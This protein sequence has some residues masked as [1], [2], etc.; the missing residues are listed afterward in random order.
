MG[1]F[2]TGAAHHIQ[3]LNNYIHYIETNAGANGN[4]HGIAVYGTFAPASI[5][6]LFI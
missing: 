3:I 2:V 1:I 6:D 5:H 4:A